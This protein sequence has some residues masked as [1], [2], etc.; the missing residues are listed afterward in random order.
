MNISPTILSWGLMPMSLL[1][2]ASSVVLSLHPQQHTL[3]SVPFFWRAGF[4]IGG[5]ATIFV[6]GMLI[7]IRWDEHTRYARTDKA[8]LLVATVAIV[9]F[10]AICIQFKYG[11]HTT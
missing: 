7:V 11:A 9:V 3:G 1:N 2:L 5:F 8:A 4:Y 10:A 6:A